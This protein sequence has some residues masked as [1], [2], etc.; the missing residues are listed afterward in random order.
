MQFIERESYITFLIK[1]EIG[2]IS[3]NSKA[4]IQ[5]KLAPA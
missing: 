1:S 3:S 2:Q 5:T 4:Q